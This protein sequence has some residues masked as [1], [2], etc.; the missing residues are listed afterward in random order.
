M[1]TFTA[2]E[3]KKLK[4]SGKLSDKEYLRVAL[5][6]KKKP[7]ESEQKKD[8]LPDILQALQRLITLETKEL[9]KPEEKIVVQ[10][11]APIVNVAAEKKEEKRKWNFTVKRDSRGLIESV[12]AIQQ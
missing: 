5:S 8:V 3:I 7:A 11:A 1:K 2:E 12:L 10:A 9:E 6:P 4:A